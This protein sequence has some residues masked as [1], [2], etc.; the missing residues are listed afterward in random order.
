MPATTVFR[1]QNPSMREPQ[2]GPR[3]RA[4]AAL[5]AKLPPHDSFNRTPVNESSLLPLK[6]FL[7]SYSVRSSAA[8]NCEIVRWLSPAS[9]D[10]F[11]ETEQPSVLDIAGLVGSVDIDREGCTLCA[12]LRDD[13]EWPASRLIEDACV[14]CSLYSAT[15][16]NDVVTFV[17][18]PPGGELSAAPDRRSGVEC[19][20]FSRFAT[21]G[22]DY[23][24]TTGLFSLCRAAIVWS[25][26]LRCAFTSS[27]GVNAS[28]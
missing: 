10:K 5:S 16:P 21:Q 24:G 1:L 26:R 14:Q 17:P 13:P 2:L 23:P 11:F 8:S 9:L 18:R 12:S 7:I 27:G 6:P 25:S 3:A 4:A 22:A 15:S 28:H 19:L 20:R